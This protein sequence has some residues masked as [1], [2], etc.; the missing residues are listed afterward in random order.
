MFPYKQYFLSH[1]SSVQLILFA[2]IILSLWIIEAVNLS[3][4]VKDKWR[5]TRTN[6]LFILTALPV[7]LIMAIFV[8]MTSAWVVSHNWGLLFLVPHHR[9]FLVKYILGFIVLDFCEYVY[10]IVMHKIK[11]F[12]RFH[13]IHHSDMGLD[14]STTVREHPGE[15]FFRMFFLIV[16]VFITGASFGVLLLRQTV[17]TIANITAHTQF[18]LQGRA[19]K[20]IGWLFITP[21]LHHVH[22]HYQLPYTDCN[23]GDVF[24]IWDRIF[25][26]YASPI[27][28]SELSYGIDSHMDQMVNARFIHILKTPLTRSGHDS[29]TKTPV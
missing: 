23:Y 20:F 4:S 28:E 21:N 7:Q 12:W 17:Q 8:L 26:T 9:S 29:Q 13:L 15:T 11:P 6:L 22:H 16:W 2:G 24:S 10:H 14:V 3:T 25:G 27:H 18:R 5:H 1:P 19:E